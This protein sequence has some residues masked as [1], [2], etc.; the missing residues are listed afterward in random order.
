MAAQT[1]IGW[2]QYLKGC[3]AVEW[4]K[5]LKGELEAKQDTRR[6]ERMIASIIERLWETSWDLWLGRNAAVYPDQALSAQ[7]ELLPVDIRPGVVG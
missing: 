1:A 5:R 2:D 3:W 4:R 6:S 7:R